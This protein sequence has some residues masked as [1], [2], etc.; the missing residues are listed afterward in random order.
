V[1]QVLL[2]LEGFEFV[3]HVLA[4]SYYRLKLDKPYLTVLEDLFPKWLSSNQISPEAMLWFLY[5][6]AIPTRAQ[7]EQFAFDVVHRAELP[8]HVKSF[9]DT[10]PVE[11]PLI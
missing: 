2:S 10:V 5:M 1:F 8:E 6:A 3:F 9:C 4:S 11:L 7:L